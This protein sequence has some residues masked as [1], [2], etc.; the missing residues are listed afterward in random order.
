MITN[1]LFGIGVM[2][3]LSS[4][5]VEPIKLKV[6]E[7]DQRDV[8]KGVVRINEKKRD[9]LGFKAELRKKRSKQIE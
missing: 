7:A 6:A 9:K 5:V 1:L 2:D 8:G 4:D 3:S